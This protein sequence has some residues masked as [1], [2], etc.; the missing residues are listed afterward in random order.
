MLNKKLL[1]DLI[2]MSIV[3]CFCITNFSFAAGVDWSKYPEKDIK[4]IIAAKA[5]GGDDRIIQTFK[6]F[7]EKYLGT[8]IVCVYKPGAGMTVAWSYIVNNTK[9]DGYTLG[10]SKVP[11]LAATEIMMKEE[12]QHEWEDI[13]PLYNIVIDPNV[14]IVKGDS[15]FNTLDDYIKYCKENP[16]TVT[17]SN[18]GVGGDDWIAAMLLQ[19][20]ARI[21]C[22]NVAYQSDPFVIQSLLGG[23]I[24]S[25]ILNVGG[26][27]DIIQDGRAKALA[28]FADE[29]VPFLP[30]V[31]TT[32]EL[33]YNITGGSSRGFAF[34]RGTPQEAIDK[35]VEALDKAANDPEFLQKA[36]EVGLNVVNMSKEEYEI[37][38]NSKL[39]EIKQIFVDAGL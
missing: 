12:K 6:P 27:L 7:L 14:L 11:H 2:I 5:G 16:Q 8:N 37:Y 13:V 10:M 1:L 18:T 21:E 23:H 4:L 30:D 33:G 17:L 29:R 22:I 3:L 31:P 39:E 35:M 20:A 25:S 32:M 15:P 26:T 36:A 19:K 38:W 9:P 34:L 24:A 28:V